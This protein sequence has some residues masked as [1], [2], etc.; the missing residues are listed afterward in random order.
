MQENLQAQQG[1]FQEE[2]AQK[3]HQLQK[4]QEQKLMEQQREQER[5]LLERQTAKSIEISGKS[6]PRWDVQDLG[7]VD[8]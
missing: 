5:Q 8:V 6:G 2:Q 1:K 3:F 4:Q 7:R